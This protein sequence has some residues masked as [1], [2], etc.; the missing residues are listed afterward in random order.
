MHTIS[1]GMIWYTENM[2]S[3]N[4]DKID[5]LLALEKENNKML[6]KMRR[7]MVWSQVFTFLYWALILGVAGWSYYFIQPYIEKYWGVYQTAMKTMADI[8]K[9]GN[10][11]PSNLESLLEKTR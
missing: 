3:D 4:Q 2:D 10:A 9:A 6:H 11:I 8:Q 7:S 1:R 5:E